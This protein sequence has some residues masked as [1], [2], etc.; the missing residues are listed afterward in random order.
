MQEVIKEKLLEIESREN[1]KIIAAIESGSRAWGFASPDSD[2]DVRFIYFRPEDEYL[3]LEKTRDVIEWQLD[4]I[5]DINGWD[6]KK[7]LQLLHNFKSLL[8]LSGVLHRSY[9]KTSQQFEKLKVLSK[10][11][12]HQRR[13]CITTGIWLREIIEITYTVMRLESKYLYVLRPILAGK[14]GN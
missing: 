12:F 3:R 6:L 5:L 4:D 2:Y 9:I 13:V 11:Y 14:M 1:V 10:R 7:T 8:F